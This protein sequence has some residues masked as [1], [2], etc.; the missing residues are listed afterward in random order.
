MPDM[1]LVIW[2]IIVWKGAPEP[3]VNVSQSLRWEGMCGGLQANPLPK[4]GPVL[5][6]DQS[7]QGFSPGRS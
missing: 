5:G 4:A 6:P 3:G 1:V 7:A 2:L